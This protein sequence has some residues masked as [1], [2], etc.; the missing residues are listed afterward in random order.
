MIC[1]SMRCVGAAGSS[2]R[3]AALWRMTRDPP[4]GGSC[5]LLQQSRGTTTATHAAQATRRRTVGLRLRGFG[6]VTET[7]FRWRVRDAVWRPTA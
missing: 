3:A 7:R 2:G 6:G 5:S 4:A 1:E